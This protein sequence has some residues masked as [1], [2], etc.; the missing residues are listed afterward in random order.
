LP[1]RR[2]AIEASAGTGKTHALAT[3]AARF[4]AEDDVA[5]SE[6]LIV[7]FTRAAANELRA[8]VRQRLVDSAELL[9]A[10]TPDPGADVD[11]L[12]HHLA[13]ADRPERTR[14]LR[15]AVTEFDAA[16]VTTIHGFAFQ[17]RAALGTGSG[18]EP[19]DRILSDHRVLL[20]EACIDVLAAAAVDRQADV[21]LPGLDDLVRFVDQVDG[22]PDLDIFP[23]AGAPSAP[24]E[25][26]V[27]ADLVVSAAELAQRRRRQAGRLS[28]DDVLTRFRSVLIDPATGAGAARYL[29]SRYRVVLIDEFQDTDP[30]QWDIFARLFGKADERSTLVLVG[31][32]KQ[33]IYGFRGADVHTYRRAVDDPSTVRQ[34]LDV[35]WRSDQALLDSLSALLTGASFGDGIGLPTVRAAPTHERRRMF[36]TDGRPLPALSL[37]LAAGED[38]ARHPH[39]EGRVVVPAAKAAILRDLAA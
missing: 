12:A 9:A 31:D 30:V 5:A 32:P 20:R 27:L 8:K 6:L 19:T 11:G 29:G 37:H 35:N 18:G 14:R 21:G 3:L 24:P 23:A 22:R 10:G 36:D 15:Q 38:I 28:F 4:V 25:L 26:A 33:S 1:R 34:A 13:S 2:T 17:V 39:H 7:T 16:T